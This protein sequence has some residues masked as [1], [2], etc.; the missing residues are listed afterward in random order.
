MT[1]VTRPLAGSRMSMPAF[2]S[3]FGFHERRRYSFL[4]LF[5]KWTLPPSGVTSTSPE[6]LGCCSRMVMVADRGKVVCFAFAAPV[7]GT[8]ILLSKSIDFR[9]AGNLGLREA[10]PERAAPEDPPEYS[11]S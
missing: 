1:T 6:G 10:R 8:V 3:V 9:G 2:G 5:S 4:S 7:V 11:R